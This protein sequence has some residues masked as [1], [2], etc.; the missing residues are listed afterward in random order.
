M[1][2]NGKAGVTYNYSFSAIDPDVDAVYF[3]IEWGDGCP[4]VEWLGPHA[5]GD[6]IVIS[7]T[8]EEKGDYSISAKVKDEYD[9]VIKY[10]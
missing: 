7:H 5:S 3:W 8:F 6:I 4:A 10:A 9:A 2:I 1:A